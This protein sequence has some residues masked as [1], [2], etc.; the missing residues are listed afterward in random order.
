MDKII[1]EG[2][3]YLHE[4]RDVNIRIPD[5]VMTKRIDRMEVA[6]AD[7]F[8]YI[9]EHPE[10]AAEIRR[11]MNYYLPTTLKLLNSYDKLSRQRVK[12]ENIQKTMFEIEGMMETIAGAFEKQLDSLFDDDAL[13]IAADIS[14]MESILKQE[15]LSGE[16]M[17]M[18]GLDPND[19]NKTQ[20]K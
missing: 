16:N 18:P 12:G 13:D 9:A 14:V 6:S 11:F 8:A 5:E 10:K 2:Y 15:G 4:L 17:K 7:I 1:E 19:T 3:K 20:T